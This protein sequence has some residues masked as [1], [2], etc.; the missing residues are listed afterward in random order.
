MPEY[1]LY[2]KGHRAIV[3]GLDTLL[4]CTIL[5]E[6]KYMNDKVQVSCTLL[7]MPNGSRVSAPTLGCAALDGVY[8]RLEVSSTTL[9]KQECDN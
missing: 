8:R 2:N 1:I 6:M 3:F 7:N 9:E 4:H 5:R